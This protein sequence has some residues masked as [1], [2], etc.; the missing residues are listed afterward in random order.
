MITNPSLVREFEREQLRATPADHA[1]NLALVESLCEEARLL[2]VWPP[3]DP[4]EGIE[5][6]LRLA[7][8]LNVRP[9]P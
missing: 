5:T 7:K 4:L 2:G 8:A 3:G 6:D 9:T 1:R